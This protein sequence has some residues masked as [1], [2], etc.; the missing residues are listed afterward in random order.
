MDYSSFLTILEPYCNE[1]YAAF[2]TKLLGKSKQTV[3]GIKT[4]IMQKIAKKY[5][6]EIDSLLSFPDEYYEVTFIKLLVVSALP[7]DQFIKYAENCVELIDNW[8]TCDC[9]RPKCLLEHK[10]E[11]LPY[12]EKLYTRGGEFRERYVLVTLLVYYIEEP[13]FSIILD[14]IKKAHTQYYYVHMAVAW[15]IAELLIRVPNVGLKALLSI[16]SDVKTYNKAIQKARESFRLTK[17]EKEQLN[18]LKIKR[19]KTKGKENGYYTND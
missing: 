2:H 12:L 1:K 10:E 17:E 4:P 19:I 18:A 14:Y 5:S 6:S 9:F 3:L 16:K 8:A 11:Y 13:Y 7:Y 15:L